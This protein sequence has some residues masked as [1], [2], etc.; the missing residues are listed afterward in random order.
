M[1]IYEEKLNNNCYFNFDLTNVYCII[2]VDNNLFT[3]FLKIIWTVKHITLKLNFIVISKTRQ[4]C[5]SN[6]MQFFI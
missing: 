1:F 6:F 3:I 4:D 5:I 2:T